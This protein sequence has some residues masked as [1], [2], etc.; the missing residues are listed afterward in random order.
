MFTR[1]DGPTVTWADGTKE[2]VAEIIQAT[3]YAP[4]LGRPAPLGALEERGRRGTATMLRRPA[5]ASPTPGCNGSEACRP[6]PCAESAAMH[7]GLPGHW[8]TPSAALSPMRL[9]RH[10]ST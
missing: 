6:L 2:H 4:D 5:P 10:V 7:G 3:G 1:T 8:V 9:I